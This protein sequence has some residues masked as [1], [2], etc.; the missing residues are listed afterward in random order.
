MAYRNTSTSP[1]R[2]V[3]IGSAHGADQIGWLAA[4]QL[5][6]AGLKQRY[7]AN[8]LDIDI[9]ESPVLLVT[10]CSAGQE[11]ILLDAYC[12]DEPV[13]SI[14]H[15]TVEDLDTNH[16]PASSHGVDLKQAL[17]LRESL[18][19]GNP[20]VSIIGICIGTEADAAAMQTPGEVLEK[21]FPALLDAIDRDIQEFIRS[22]AR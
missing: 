3:G 13:G 17:A 19:D 2:I 12:S 9:C 7:P 22:T 10:Q 8:L 5:D 16:R 20:P 1:V 15:F 14:R 6:A 18:E 11:L 4:R 21:T